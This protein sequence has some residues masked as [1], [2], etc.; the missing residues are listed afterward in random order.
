M[1]HVH[2][3]I[4]LFNT[5]NF[6][7]KEKL[8]N[9]CSCKNPSCFRFSIFILGKKFVSFEP[10]QKSSYYGFNTFTFLW[11]SFPIYASEINFLSIKMFLNVLSFKLHI[12]ILHI[13]VL[14]ILTFY[15]LM[16]K[17]KNGLYTFSFYHKRCFYKEYSPPGERELLQGVTCRL[18]STYQKL[19]SK[20]QGINILCLSYMSNLIFFQIQVKL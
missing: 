18:S 16:F 2:L 8:N 10:L 5:T 20:A 1:L 4:L 7:I 15:K 11:I 19:R 3:F 13:N 17:L 12:N 14:V 6:L 9:M